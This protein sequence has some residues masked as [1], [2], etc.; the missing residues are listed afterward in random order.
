MTRAEAVETFRREVVEELAKA[1]E[2]EIAVGKRA[3]E[4]ADPA[5]RKDMSPEDLRLM[6][7]VTEAFIFTIRNWNGEK[8]DGG[9]VIHE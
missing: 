1:M 3:M 5:V 8:W 4:A 2:G 7:E 6:L 9:G